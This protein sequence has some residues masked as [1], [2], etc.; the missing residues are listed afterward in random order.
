MNEAKLKI[1]KAKAIHNQKTRV[2]KSKKNKIKVWMTTRQLVDAINGRFEYTPHGMIRIN[3]KWNLQIRGKH[4]RR[5][6]KKMRIKQIGRY[7]MK[8]E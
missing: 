6:K 3:S 5:L 1:A 4:M 2:K 8:D 7:I